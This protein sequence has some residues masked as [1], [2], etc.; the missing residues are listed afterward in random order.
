MSDLDRAA[1]FYL[2]ALDGHWLFKPATNPGPGAQAV[3][4]GGPE[5]AFRF[6]YIG[7]ESGAVELIE[8][9]AEPPAWAAG[10]AAGRLL[11]HFGLVVDDVEAT[12]ARIERAGGSRVWP[13]PAKW[14]SAT[15]M[16]AADPDGNPFELFDVS[17]EGIV[18][19]TI[20]MFPESAP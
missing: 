14:G 10:G 8:F 3:F 2:G 20:E 7:F 1:E 15:V 4:G 13:R 18:D 12:T 17:L 5:T 6:C 19:L 11:P 16:Y 9:T